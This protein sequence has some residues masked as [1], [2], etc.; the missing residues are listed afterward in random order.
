MPR[1][2][3]CR[4]FDRP[5][6]A[7]GIRIWSLIKRCEPDPSLR[8]VCAGLDA[9]YGNSKYETNSKCKT[10]MFQTKRTHDLLDVLNVALL[11]L[12]S[13]RVEVHYES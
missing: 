7:S 4:P 6:Y 5:G 12:A 2:A 3:Q 11:L 10:R 1:A 9:P 13:C 8:C